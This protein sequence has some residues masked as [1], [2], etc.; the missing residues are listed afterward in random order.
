MIKMNFMRPCLKTILHTWLFEP[1]S[2]WDFCKDEKLMEQ[3]RRNWLS[4]LRSI[5]S[6][7]TWWR[8]AFT[9]FT[10][11]PFLTPNSKL[12]F[13]LQVME[14][15]PPPPPI[16]NLPPPPRPPDLPCPLEDQQQARP[17][18]HQSSAASLPVVKDLFQESCDIN[19]VIDSRL[20]LGEN[21]F[22]LLIVL[23]CSCI[24]VGIVMT[25]GLLIYRLV[26]S[27]QNCLSQ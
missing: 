17:L 7:L 14:E 16:F 22:T 4:S 20:Y 21:L 9:S 25:V 2:K 18:H 8:R 13:V 23:V 6:I 27:K 26:T 1:W 10:H 12:V 19:Y 11:P 15:A 5:D 3:P 24:L